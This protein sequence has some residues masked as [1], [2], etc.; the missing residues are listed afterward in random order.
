M[1]V[2]IQLPC[3]CASRW[4]T[5]ARRCSQVFASKYRPS[6]ELSSLLAAS[7]ALQK[8]IGFPLLFLSA[9]IFKTSDVQDVLDVEGGLSFALHLLGV[10]LHDD[11][12][13][14]ALRGALLNE[15]RTDIVP[16]EP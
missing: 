6:E 4:L 10:A 13:L 8:L 3:A 12:H 9:A 5:Y 15:L 16:L 14:A 7:L 2:H 11:G 1:H